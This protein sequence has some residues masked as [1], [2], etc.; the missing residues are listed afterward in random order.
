MRL[1]REPE[2]IAALQNAKSLGFDVWTLLEDEDLASLR[3][4]PEVVALL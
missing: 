2:A 1:G 4:H 3:A